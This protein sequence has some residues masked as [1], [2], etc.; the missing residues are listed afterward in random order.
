MLKNMKDRLQ[1]AINQGKITQKRIN[2]LKDKQKN[3][4]KN[5]FER[6]RN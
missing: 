4:T 5:K 3:A 1:E 6:T 2:I